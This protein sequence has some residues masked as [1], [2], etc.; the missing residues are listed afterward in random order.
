MI[1]AKSY[2]NALI[3]ASRLSNVELTA[4]L[5]VLLDR[6]IQRQL[7][8]ILLEPTASQILDTLEVPTVIQS[9]LQVLKDDKVLHRLDAIAS[10]GL[11]IVVSQGIATPVRLTTVRPLEVDIK[12]R[13]ED[14]LGRVT[15]PVVLESKTDPR[16]LGGF[17]LEIGKEQIDQ[18]IESRLAVLGAQ[19]QMKA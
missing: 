2:A 11:T 13:I 9:F 3:A 1:S 4:W 16:I 15:H 10:Q 17:R 18:T 7:S 5:L 14:A 19:L 6:S 8:K 12:Q